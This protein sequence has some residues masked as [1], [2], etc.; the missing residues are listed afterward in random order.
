MTVLDFIGYIASIIIL[1]SIVSSSIVRL[2]VI[3][4]FGSVLFAV[5]GFLIHSIPTGIM[6]AMIALVNVYFLAKMLHNKEFFTILQTQQNDQY[7][8][9]FLEFYKAEIKKYYPE[10]EVDT[11]N[12]DVSFYVLRDMTTAGLFLGKRVE[13]DSLLINLDFVIPEYRDFKAGKYIYNNRE[14]LFSDMGYKRFLVHSYDK[15]NSNYLKKM[16]FTEDPSKAGLFIKQIN[17]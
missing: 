16:G 8:L 13:D 9:R 11:K 2:R 7:L 5:Y 15:D 17:S 3:N 14:K 1:I 6:N 12:N 10:F 4:F